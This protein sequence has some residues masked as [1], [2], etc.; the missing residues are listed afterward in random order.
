[1]KIGIISHFGRPKGQYVAAMSLRPVASALA[2]LLKKPVSFA[3]N[4]IGEAAQSALNKLPDGGICV[5]ENTRFHGGETAND[6]DFAKQLAT[7]HKP[8]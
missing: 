2:E 5:L 4:C 3:E 6:S 8:L 1:M 7:P